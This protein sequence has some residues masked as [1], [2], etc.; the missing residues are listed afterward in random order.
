MRPR[1]TH[2]ETTQ[3]SAMIQASPADN[4]SDLRRLATGYARRCLTCDR[5]PVIERE[6][7]ICF[8]DINPSVWS[9]CKDARRE[10]IGSNVESAKD[11]T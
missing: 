4:D 3:E 10:L 7:L 5:K 1:A 6:R 8:R 9:C 11:L 2:Q